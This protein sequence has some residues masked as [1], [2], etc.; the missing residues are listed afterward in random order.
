MHVRTIEHL[1]HLFAP[2]FF[3]TC[4]REEEEEEEED[5]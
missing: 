4:E 3:T 1:T 2:T 5:C